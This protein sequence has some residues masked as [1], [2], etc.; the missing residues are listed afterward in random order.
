MEARDPALV[1]AEYKIAKRPKGR[2]LVDYNQNAW[3]RTLASIYSVRP[4]P[5]ATVSTPVTWEEIEKGVRIEDFRMDNVPARIAKRGDLWKYRCA[6]GKA[7]GASKP[8]KPGPK[9][10]PTPENEPSLD[11]PDPPPY[12]PMEG[13]SRRGDPQRAA[14][15]VRAEVGR[16]SLRRVQ[17]RRR[18]RAPVEGR[19]AA[20]AL[21]PGDRRDSRGA[22]GVPVRPRRRDRDPGREEPSPSTICSS[23]STPPKAASGSSR[24]KRPAILTWSS[25]CSWTRR[26]GWS[27]R[28]ARP[29]GGEARGVREETPR[30]GEDIRLFARPR[31]TARSR[32][33]GCAARAARSTA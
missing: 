10:A 21:L 28:G 13:A 6:G 4:K 32:R 17:G 15:A 2:V 9:N 23:A 18:D 30:E 3:G 29:S 20:R 31:R 26:A 8:P 27:R 24:R 14:L 22:E 16:L 12:L 7:P 33:S 1:T 5:K 11:P 19:P 25:T